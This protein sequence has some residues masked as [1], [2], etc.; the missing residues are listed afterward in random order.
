MTFG[1]KVLGSTGA[2]HYDSSAVT[3]N[4]LGLFLITGNTSYTIDTAPFT[5]FLVTAWFLNV[6]PLDRKL[7]LPTCTVSANTFTAVRNG[8]DA[9]ALVL[10]R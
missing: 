1:M 8:V 7:L 9:Y 5:E 3:W 4:Q 2:V 10:G 6:P